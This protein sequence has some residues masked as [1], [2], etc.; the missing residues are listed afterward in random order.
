MR[1]V[2][3]IRQELKW[4]LP[5]SSIDMESKHTNKYVVMRF[6]AEVL[7][8]LHVPIKNVER[9]FRGRWVQAERL[10]YDHAQVDKVCTVFKP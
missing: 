5:V 2:K 8:K 7:A 1:R 10:I 9:C 4:A 3:A 6:H